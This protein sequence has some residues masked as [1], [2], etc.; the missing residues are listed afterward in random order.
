MYTVFARIAPMTCV[1]YCTSELPHAIV[2]CAWLNGN[3]YARGMYVHVHLYARAK[4]GVWFGPRGR[5][6][7]VPFAVLVRAETKERLSWQR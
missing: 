4:G 3:V 5:V 2:Q 6:T 7:G 1:V